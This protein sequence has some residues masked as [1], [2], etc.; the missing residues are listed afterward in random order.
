MNTTSRLLLATLATTAALSTAGTTAYATN[1][2]PSPDDS[3]SPDVNSVLCP[4]ASSGLIGTV[5]NDL[6]SQS[7]PKSC[8]SSSAHG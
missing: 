2:G 5:L 8:G 4:I 6:N 1:A 3:A 7:L